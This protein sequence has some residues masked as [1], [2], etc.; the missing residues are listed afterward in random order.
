M[1]RKKLHKHIIYKI[2]AQSIKKTILFILLK[3]KQNECSQEMKGCYRS[4][5]S[6][7]RFRNVNA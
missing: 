6:R 4:M 2:I 5:I 3:Q 1:T 7:Y